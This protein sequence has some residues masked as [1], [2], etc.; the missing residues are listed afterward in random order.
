MIAIRYDYRPAQGIDNTKKVVEFIGADAY[1]CPTCGGS[2]EYEAEDGPHGCNLC[3]SRL[4][5]FVD[6]N[7]NMKTVDWGEYIG[8]DE[9]GLHKLKVLHLVTQRDQP[10]GSARKCCEKCGLGIHMM[11]GDAHGELYTDDPFAYYED[12]LLHTEWTRCNKLDLM[13]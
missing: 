1:K 2:G 10:Y 5:A 11:T 4:L 8:R 13:E 12:R 3:N 6:A 9:H 7:G